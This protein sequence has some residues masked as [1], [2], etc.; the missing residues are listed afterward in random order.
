MSKPSI[1]INDRDKIIDR[2]MTD[3]EFAQFEKDQ[4]T[5]KAD[6]AAMKLAEDR[7]QS[8]LAKLQELGLSVNDLKAL[9]L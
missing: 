7:R 4:E 2:E 3:E 5:I 8:A 9:G 1:R 6:K